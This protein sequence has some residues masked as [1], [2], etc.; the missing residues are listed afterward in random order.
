MPDG[1]YIHGLPFPPDYPLENVYGKSKKE[2]NKLVRDLYKDKI[3]NPLENKRPIKVTFTKTGEIENI[4]V[5]DIYPIVK[6]I[7]INSDK[8]RSMRKKLDARDGP[9][10]KCHWCNGEMITLGSSNQNNYKTIEHLVRRADGGKHILDNCV[11]A[12]RK[13]NTSRHFKKKNK[14]ITK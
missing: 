9:S 5:T 14:S 1:C 2:I 12:C 3:T 10:P 13:C 11:Y 7:K 4:L 8:N 6:K